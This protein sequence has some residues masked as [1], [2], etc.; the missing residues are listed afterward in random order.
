MLVVYFALSW[1]VASGFLCCFFRAN[2][3]LVACFVLCVACEKALLGFSIRSRQS[4][5][6]EL[7]CR[8]CFVPREWSQ[9]LS[10]CGVCCMFYCTGWMLLGLALVV[11]SHQFYPIYRAGSFFP[12][13]SA[14]CFSF[15]ILGRLDWSI[16][17][18]LG[19]Y[20]FLVLPAW[21][22]QIPCLVFVAYVPVVG[23]DIGAWMIPL[24][25][26]ASQ[27]EY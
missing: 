12:A 23:A 3:I 13:R 4:A 9:I 14:N 7:A 6:G 20:R 18:F 10:V 8:L 19:W 22:L 27:T 1:S 17:R 25:A 21:S 11:W 16:I 2:L 26:Q 15:S 24:S 5:S